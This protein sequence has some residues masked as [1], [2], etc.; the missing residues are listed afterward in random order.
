MNDP[1]RVATR[2]F[3]SRVSHTAARAH[4]LPPDLRREAEQ[5][6]DM[7][8]VLY[9]RNVSRRTRGRVARIRAGATAVQS[10]HRNWK[11][12]VDDE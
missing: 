4:Y 2:R 1:R 8:D 6:R 11:D 9:A 10:R 5:L 7:I 3:R 12:H